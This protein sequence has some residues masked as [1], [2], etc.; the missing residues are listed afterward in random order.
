MGSQ[1]LTPRAGQAFIPLCLRQ[2]GMPAVALDPR[3]QFGWK[4]STNQPG[5]GPHPI[6]GLS[7]TQ[8]LVQNLWPV[9]VK[10]QLCQPSPIG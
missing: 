2:R 3:V 4:W 5:S 7:I 6:Q 8:M 10:M 9:Y 1:F